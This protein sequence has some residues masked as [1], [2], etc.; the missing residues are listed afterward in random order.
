VS[1]VR[2][3]F[4]LFL[5]STIALPSQAKAQQ[6]DK[7]TEE[8]A[9]AFLGNPEA[10]KLAYVAAARKALMKSIK[11]DPILRANPPAAETFMRDKLKVLDKY[12]NGESFRNGWTEA[13]LKDAVAMGNALPLSTQAHFPVHVLNLG[14]EKLL[15]SRASEGRTPQ[16][17]P[18]M[19]TSV[20]A[21]LL[22]SAK[23]PNDP[24]QA[25]AK[26]VLGKYLKIDTTVPYQFLPE[27]RIT[28]Q[29]RT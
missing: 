6:A 29:Y 21:G 26:E 3:F 25:W 27:V 8:A 11:S 13:L 20:I 19:V 15:D 22:R 16:L 28:L 7:L 9:S 17:P 14:I 24:E 4:R 10:Y 12:V 23:T 5:V 18:D 1:A 2:T